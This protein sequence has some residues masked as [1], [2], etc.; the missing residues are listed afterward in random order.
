MLTLIVIIAVVFVLIMAIGS[1]EHAADGFVRFCIALCTCATVIGF[2]LL[3]VG[4]M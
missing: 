4:E 1:A 3:I 2:Y